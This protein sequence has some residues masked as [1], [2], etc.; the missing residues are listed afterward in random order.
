MT[1]L[2]IVIYGI[3]TLFNIDD[4]DDG[5]ST[6]KNSN[7][8]SKKTRHELHVDFDSFRRQYMVVYLVIMLADWM[9]GTHMYTL[10]MHT[11]ISIWVHTYIQT[12]K[13]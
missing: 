12:D 10:Y 13:K 3:S 4:E 8:S 11:Y 6:K 5:K 1:G 9:Q 2:L 7:G